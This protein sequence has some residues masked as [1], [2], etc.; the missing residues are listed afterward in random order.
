M[1]KLLVCCAAA[2][3]F[4]Y[5]LCA[6][7]AY[8]PANLKGFA[9]S[10]YEQGF[11]TEAESEYKRYFF[12]T[13]SNKIDESAVL[14][15]THIYF[16]QKNKTGLNFIKQNLKAS[17]GF[18]TQEQINYVDFSFAFSEKNRDVFHLYYASLLEDTERLEKLCPEWKVVYALSYEVLQKNIKQAGMTANKGLEYSSVFAPVVVSC[19]KYKQKS[20]ALALSMS[21]VIPGSGKWYS[22]NFWTGLSDLLGIGSFTAASVYYGMEKGAKDWR[23]WTYGSIAAVLYVVDLYG[24]YTGVRRY[25][26]AQYYNLC[27]KVEELYDQLY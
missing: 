3:V 27:T 5:G 23:P 24:S 12:I 26:Q 16:N 6:Q 21:A 17:C 13:D 14:N 19:D 1:K 11:W 15:L 9:D 8:S 20:P 7:N 4:I 10:L 18:K 25:N 22:G 2:F